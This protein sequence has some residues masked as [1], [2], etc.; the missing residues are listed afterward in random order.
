MNQRKKLKYEAPLIEV[1]EMENEGVMASS[2][3]D[4]GQKPWGRSATSPTTRSVGYGTASSASE[5]EDLINDILT[6]EN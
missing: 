3:S 6:V 1:I 4:M 2:M 5:L